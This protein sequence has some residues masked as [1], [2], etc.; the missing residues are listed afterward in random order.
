MPDKNIKNQNSLISIFD[1]FDYREYLSDVFAGMKKKRHGFSFRVF[2]REAGIESHNFLPRILQRRR[3]LTGKFISLIIDYIELSHREERYFRALV[4]F[5]NA[6]KL[7]EKEQSL[8]LMLSMR[9]TND[10]YKLEDKKLRFFE[11][12]YYPVIRE[13]AIM[14]DFK[15]DFNLL[16]RKCIP[17]ITAAQAKSAMEFLTK[18]GFL[19]VN[20][21]GGYATSEPILSTEAEVNSAIISKYHKTTLTQCADA[22]ETMKKEKRNFTSSTLRIS[23]DMYEEMKNEIFHLRKHFLGMAKQCENPEMVCFAGF[24]LLPRS[25]IITGND[26]YKNRIKKTCRKPG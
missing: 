4:S 6:K 9:V 8:K 15:N 16:A 20:K 10:E 1:Y 23:V 25:E 11:K 18:N 22:V 13:L 14:L 12:W 3:N 5:N 7:S 24:Q 17:R 26:T 2:S 19:T 21:N